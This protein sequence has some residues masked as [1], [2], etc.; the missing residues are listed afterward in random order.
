MAE[1]VGGRQSLRCECGHHKERRWTEREA[2]SGR[3]RSVAVEV[4]QVPGLWVEYSLFGWDL[5][6]LNRMSEKRI[7]QTP[8]E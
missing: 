8:K 2:F 4:G 1:H 7:V 5:C 3:L 6:I